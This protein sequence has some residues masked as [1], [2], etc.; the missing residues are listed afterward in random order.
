MHRNPFKYRNPFRQAPA[1]RVAAGLALAA[2]AVVLLL[3]AD[4]APALAAPVAPL[5]APKSLGEILSGIRTWLMTILA[6]I[7]TVFLTIGGVRYLM[8]GGDPSEVER[9]KSAFKSAGI[10]YALAIIAP[11][12]L[13]ILNQIVGTPQ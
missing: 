11:V 9:A 7:A 4:P 3:L 1:A 2:A 8:A 10:G 5:A 6:G 13:T 12:V